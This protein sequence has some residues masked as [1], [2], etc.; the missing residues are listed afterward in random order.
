MDL[1]TN[2]VLRHLYEALH[3]RKRLAD[4]GG[5]ISNLQLFY[6]R[7]TREYSGASETRSEKKSQWSLTLSMHQST[8][9]P[10]SHWCVVVPLTEQD[11]D[12][13]YARKMT[14]E[15]FLEVIRTKVRFII[16][17]NLFFRH[18]AT[19]GVSHPLDPHSIVAVL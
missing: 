3:A 10:E 19:Q 4:S 8:S 7:L 13:F 14:R 2:N 17:L 15:G 12:D 11:V 18:T 5:N 16:L 1:V 6:N 9:Q